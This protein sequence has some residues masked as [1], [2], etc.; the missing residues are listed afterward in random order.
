MGS[1]KRGMIGNRCFLGIEPLR[2]G[3]QKTEPLGGHSGDHFGSNPPPRPCFAHHQH[4]SSTG[5]RSKD[6]IS[7]DR[8]YGAEIND[9]DIV[10]VMAEFLGRGE[11]LVKHGAVGHHGC[12]P[13]GTR[14][15]GLPKRKRLLGKIF[16]LRW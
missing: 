2:R 5:N 11:G 4:P 1:P 12:V 13:A 14:D 8:S 7:V 9:L 3:V 6:R 15:P 10:S 16:C